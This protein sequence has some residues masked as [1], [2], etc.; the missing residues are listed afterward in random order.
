MAGER[1][2]D[3]APHSPLDQIKIRWRLRATTPR[4]RGYDGK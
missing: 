2:D 4:K 3:L 1:I